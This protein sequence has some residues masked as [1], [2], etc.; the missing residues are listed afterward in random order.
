MVMVMVMI[1]DEECREQSKQNR[2]ESDEDVEERKGKGDRR[3][4]GVGRQRRA[5]LKSLLYQLRFEEDSSPIKTRR[6]RGLGFKTVQA[7]QQEENR[8]R[9]LRYPKPAAGKQGPSGKTQTPKR[10]VVKISSG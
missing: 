2:L 8:E 6:G 4:D 1:K 7:G 5:K 9:I 3:M 10:R